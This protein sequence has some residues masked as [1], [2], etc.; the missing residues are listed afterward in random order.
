MRTE[1]PSHVPRRGGAVIWLT[2]LSAAGKSTI[3]FYL[4]QQL[5]AQE[6]HV[7]VLDGDSL[8]E[9]LCADLGFS[10]E[11]R[12]E[13]VRRVAEVARLVA[14]TGAVTIVALISPYRRDRAHARDIVARGSASSAFLE[15]FVDAP[16]SVCEGRDPKGLYAKARAGV[17]P[18]F[19]GVSAPYEPPDAPDLIIQTD[20]CTVEDAGDLIV[21]L[22]AGTAA[23]SRPRS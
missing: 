14:A 6:R 11:D 18:E 16:L 20:R 2:G 5:L 21:A 23:A 3:A 17:I 8:R 10:P 12:A 13:N 19:T 22:L 4:Q 7:A 15:V 1:D 9:G